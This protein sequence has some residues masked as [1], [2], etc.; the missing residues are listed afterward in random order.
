ML[1]M[2]IISHF[3]RVII[4][5][6]INYTQLK[7]KQFLKLVNGKRLK[8]RPDE[9][10]LCSLTVDHLKVLKIYKIKLYFYLK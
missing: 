7:Q 4:C 10:K 9:V 2:F 8:I 6:L 5:F 1:S 3:F